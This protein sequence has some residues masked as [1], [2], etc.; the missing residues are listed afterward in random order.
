MNNVVP[1]RLAARHGAREARKV[2]A[3]ARRPL[4][5]AHDQP[6]RGFVALALW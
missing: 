5:G 6:D 4:L 1:F 3:P 2:P